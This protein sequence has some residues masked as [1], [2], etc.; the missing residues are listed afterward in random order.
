MSLKQI[1]P[2]VFEDDVA[3]IVSVGKYD[4]AIVSFDYADE[5]DFESGQELDQVLFLLG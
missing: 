3:F 4:V 5:E 1:S 2:F